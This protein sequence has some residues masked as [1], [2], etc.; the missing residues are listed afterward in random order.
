MLTVCF[1]SGNVCFSS[2]QKLLLVDNLAKGFDLYDYPHRLPSE[3]FPVSRG[4]AF[5]QQGIFLEDKTSVAC[6]TDHGN[7]HI[8]SLGTSKCL[9]KLKHGSAKTM[10]QVLDVCRS[11]CRLIVDYLMNKFRLVQ[12]RI[13]TSSQVEQMGRNQ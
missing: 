12:L 3:S 10:V 4:K 13:N 11:F 7:I 2:D 6:G 8:F 5:V 1:H 9:Q